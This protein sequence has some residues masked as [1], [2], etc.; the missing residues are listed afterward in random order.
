VIDRQFVE[1]IPLNGRS[2]Q[3]LILLA[4][5]TITNTPQ[6][7]SNLGAQGEFSVD[8]QRTESNYYTVDGVSAN[9]G[10]STINGGAGITGSLPASTAL[11][12]TQGLVS[13]DALQ[14]FRVESSTYSAE[15][16]RNPGGQFAMVTR[17]GTDD[18]HGTAFDYFR[19]DALDA[20]SW[21]NEERRRAPKRLWRNIWRTNKDSS[22]LRRKGQELLLLLV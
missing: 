21:F 15:Y 22:S 17:S 11:G 4:P 5:G 8:G 14:E 16:G 12:T 10:A 6:R 19:N 7:T 13:V 2:F 1:N 3:D 9:S 20:N 18:W